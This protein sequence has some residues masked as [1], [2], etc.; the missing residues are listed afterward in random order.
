[1]ERFSEKLYV[2][3]GKSDEGLAGLFYYSNII[4]TNE[5]A[6]MLGRDYPWVAACMLFVWF[7]MTVHL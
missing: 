4:R 2:D 5:M 3:N 1:M 7:Y 6:D